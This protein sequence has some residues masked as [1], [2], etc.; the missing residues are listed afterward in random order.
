MKICVITKDIGRIVGI[1]PTAE[2]KAT[3]KDAPKGVSI[4]PQ[5]GQTIHVVTL[6]KELEKVP[7]PTLAKSFRVKDGQLVPIPE[8]YQQPKKRK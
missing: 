7:L 1:V 2:I 4:H 8:A 5:E 3:G 6:P